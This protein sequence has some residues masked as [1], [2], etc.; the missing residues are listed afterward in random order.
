MPMFDF[1][2]PKCGGVFEAFVPLSKLEE[3]VVCPLCGEVLERKFP[4]PRLIKVN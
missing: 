3:A 2:C 1:S 4:A